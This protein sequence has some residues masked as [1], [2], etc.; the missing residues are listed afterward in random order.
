MASLTIKEAALAL[1]IDLGMY[2]L[3]DLMKQQSKAQGHGS[4]FYNEVLYDMAVLQ[5]AIDGRR[6][7]TLEEWSRPGGQSNDKRD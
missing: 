6:Q 2:K 1:L 5:A 4:T 7:P 3:P